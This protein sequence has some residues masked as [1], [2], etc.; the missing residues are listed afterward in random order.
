M[1][2]GNSVLS[3][4]EMAVP[5]SH[6]IYE[7][8]EN[9]F[10]FANKGVL[11]PQKANKYSN[12]YGALWTLNIF[13]VVGQGLYKLKQFKDSKDTQNGKLQKKMIYIDIISNLC[14]IPNAFGGSGIPFYLTGKTFCDTTIGIGSGI[15]ASLAIWNYRLYEKQ[16][17][18][19]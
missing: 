16:N 12:I 19:L 13:V 8:Y 17:N 15:A 11:N 18:K 5:A 1:I 14:D 7:I 10:Y 9:A 4:F 2:N 3:L 6:F